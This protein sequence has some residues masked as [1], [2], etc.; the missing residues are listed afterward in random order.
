MSKIPLLLQ[1]EKLLR[2]PADFLDNI[3]TED[4][5]NFLTEDGSFILLE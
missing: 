3:L 2:N 4:S 1:K 5:F